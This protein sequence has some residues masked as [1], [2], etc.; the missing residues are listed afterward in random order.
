MT[1]FGHKPICEDSYILMFK[2]QGQTYPQIGP[3]FPVNNTEHWFLQMY[4][5]VDT[6]EQMAC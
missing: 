1:S 4:F 2:I 3:I 5:M 6:T